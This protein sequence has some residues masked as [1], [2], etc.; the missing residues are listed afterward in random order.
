MN[1]ITV[2]PCGCAFGTMVN[3]GVVNEFVVA[4]C[5]IRCKYYQYILEES[6]AQS[7]PVE[8]KHVE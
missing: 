7:K 3:N 8:I 5:D 4:P 6:K 1:D 2:L